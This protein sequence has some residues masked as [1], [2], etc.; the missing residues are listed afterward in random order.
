MWA[1]LVCAKVGVRSP[2]EKR[3]PFVTSF[4][5]SVASRFLTYKGAQER[6]LLHGGSLVWIRD[7][8]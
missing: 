3:K 6:F 5:R 7:W 2:I 1:H 8:S 4:P